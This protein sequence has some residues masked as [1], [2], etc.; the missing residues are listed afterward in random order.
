[1]GAVVANITEPDGVLTLLQQI[2]TSVHE[3]ESVYVGATRELTQAA[4]VNGFPRWPR[5]SRNGTGTGR[6]TGLARK[7][8]DILR[9]GPLTVAQ[10][11]ERLAEDQFPYSPKS[12]GVLLSRQFARNDDG[13]WQHR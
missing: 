4:G 13:H 3:L 1:M 11:R 10:L 7:V 6:H 12:L 5:V 9:T 2:H 8:S